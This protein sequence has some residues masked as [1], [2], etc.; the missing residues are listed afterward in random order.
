M[1]D[2]LGDDDGDGSGGE[3]GDDGGGGR[4]GGCVAVT[5]VLNGGYGGRGSGTSA[6]G[7]EVHISRAVA[8]LLLL[9]MMGTWS[10]CLPRLNSFLGLMQPHSSSHELILIDL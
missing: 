1:D 4:G 3:D 5:D 9:M 7:E 2:G 8:Y 6:Q 10:E